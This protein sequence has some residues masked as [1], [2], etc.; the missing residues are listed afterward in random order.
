MPWKNQN[1][2][3][4][5]IQPREY[6]REAKW[7][8]RFFH[9]QMASD[10]MISIAL[11]AHHQGA[12]LRGIQIV[13]KSVFKKTPCAPTLIRWK[14][15][16]SPLV[17]R[18]C[19]HAKSLGNVIL[20]KGRIV[21]NKLEELCRNFIPKLAGIDVLER[22]KAFMASN[23]MWR[24]YGNVGHAGRPA[25]FD[26]KE[27]ERRYGRQ[28]YRTHPAY[29]RTLVK[30]PENLYSRLTIRALTPEQKLERKRKYHRDW[31]RKKAR[32][33]REKQL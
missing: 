12:S 9:W 32:E 8:H 23:N 29:A 10:E 25:R 13:C 11:M 24:P 33:K 17:C 28:Y 3:R 7:V 21:P 2:L 26:Q 15:K 14:R 5:G 18:I 6:Y 30:H 4:K 1:Q 16:F 27:W 20:C 19:A 31:A 22:T